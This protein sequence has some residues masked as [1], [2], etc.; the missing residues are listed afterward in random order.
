MKSDE[1]VGSTYLEEFILSLDI[2]PNNFRRESELVRNCII[3]ELLLIVN[4]LFTLQMQ[5]KELDREVCELNKEITTLEES[6]LSNLKEIRE[7]EAKDQAMQLEQ[8]NGK[9]QSDI[10]TIHER[11][12]SKMAEKS[13][14]IANL[15]VIVDQYSMKLDNDLISFEQE[16]KGSGEYEA[17]RGFPPETE[18]AFTV[19]SDSSGERNYILG[20]VSNYRPELNVYEIID[21]DDQQTYTVSETQVVGLN[22]ADSQR[23]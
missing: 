19:S 7:L 21:V 4:H 2:L 13:A 11:I 17:P 6:Y 5:M 9:I 22:I 3:S 12:S 15:I 1:N 8:V 14:I 23:R 10:Q 20:K 18:V 16:L